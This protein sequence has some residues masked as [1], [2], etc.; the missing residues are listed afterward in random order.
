MIRSLLVAV[1]SSAHA[2]AAL[3]HAVGLAG[4]YQARITGLNVLDVRYVEMPP[5]LDYAYSFEAVPPAPIWSRSSWPPPMWCS[6][7]SRPGQHQRLSPRARRIW[8]SWA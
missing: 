7:A 4:A 3:E 2:K 6:Q 5:Y 1:D 8:W